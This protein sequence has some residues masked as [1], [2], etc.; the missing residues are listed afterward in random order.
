MIIKRRVESNVFEKDI[1]SG[2]WETRSLR[3]ESRRHEENIHRLPP[4]RPRQK[5]KAR[6]IGARDI[7][8][9]DSQERRPSGSRQNVNFT[10]QQ[11]EALDATHPTRTRRGF[12]DHVITT[13]PESVNSP[14]R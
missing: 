12:D 1:I 3:R 6:A 7:K 2:G 13:G 4:E 5:S 11:D 9:H 8:A 10:A 14:V